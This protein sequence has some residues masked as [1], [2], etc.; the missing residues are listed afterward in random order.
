MSET[1]HILSVLK[2]I[3]I[4]KSCAIENVMSAYAEEKKQ[5]VLEDELP[6]LP[7]KE[8]PA[9][10]LEIKEEI[11]VTPSSRI[12]RC[13]WQGMNFVLKR[14]RTLND[15][16]DISKYQFEIYEERK[17]GFNNEKKIL[18]E[19]RLHYSPYI[20]TSFICH[21][22]FYLV[23]QEQP[24]TLFNIVMSN[25]ELPWSKKYKIM[26]DI[27]QGVAFLHQHYILHLDIKAQNIL[28]DYYDVPKICDF[29]LSVKLN[30]KMDINQQV[31]EINRGTLGWV[32]PELLTLKQGSIKS[33]IYSLGVT[34]WQIATREYPFAKLDLIPSGEI[35]IYKLTV[36]GQ[37]FSFLEPNL[38]ATPKQVKDCI[39]RCL[40]F[41]SEDRP[42]A[43]QCIE[44]SCNFTDNIKEAAD[45]L[46]KNVSCH[47]GHHGSF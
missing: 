9:I 7:I 22:P 16:E 34:F 1:R 26:Q 23:L 39:R 43:T 25:R 44:L 14:F 40:N 29:G 38:H 13:K 32:A 12:L 21:E 4:S 41:F 8:I 24:F 37:A 30:P 11:A 46:S 42:N 47:A 6:V 35:E 33:D 31:V 3:Q 28:L 10:E 5:A 36:D 20:I 17:K 18:N 27:S 45:F 15:Q 19:L 2:Q